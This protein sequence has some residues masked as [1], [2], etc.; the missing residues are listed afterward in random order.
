VTDSQAIDAQAVAAAVQAVAAVLVAILT[1]QLIVATNAYVAA[2]HEQLAELREARAA[3]THPRFI[4]S[5]WGTRAVV[6][7]RRRYNSAL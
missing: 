2:S 6:R 5:G 3:A 7:D 4:R 1:W